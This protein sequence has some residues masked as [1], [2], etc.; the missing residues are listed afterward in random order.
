MTIKGVLFDFSGTLLRIETTESW[1]RAVLAEAGTVLPEPEF[2][3]CAQ[4]LEYVGALPG[5]TP[6]PRVPDHLRDIWAVRDESAD[7]HRIAYTGL[8]GVVDLPHPGL[9]DALYNRH[10]TPPAWGPYP[11]TAAV[12]AGLRERGIRV[13]VLSNIGWDLRPVFREHGLDQYVDTYVLSYEHGIQKPDPRLFGIALE[14]LGVAP[15]DALMVGDDRHADGG[16]AQLGCA[17]HFVDHLPAHER[18]GQ[19]L[20][21]LGLV[22]GSAG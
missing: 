5:G 17:V 8:S 18:P 2:R 22:D 1:L 13:G 12:L 16:A 4:E 19:L 9:H 3:R 10:M 15:E 6:S 20:P 7:N 14:Q 21:V 11:D